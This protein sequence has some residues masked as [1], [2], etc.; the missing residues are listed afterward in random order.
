MNG[1]SGRWFSSW[2]G[3][4]PAESTPEK[5]EDWPQNPGIFPKKRRA[6]K[7]DDDIL[8]ILFAI[9]GKIL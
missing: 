9:W 3:P 6:L 4:L 8:A 2:F 1:W 7:D 5:V